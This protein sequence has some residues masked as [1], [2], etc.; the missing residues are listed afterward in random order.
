MRSLSQKTKNRG[1]YVITRIFGRYSFYR[2]NLLNRD[3]YLFSVKK[4][5]SHI[6]IFWISSS[7]CH[8]LHNNSWNIFIL[9]QSTSLLFLLL[10]DIWWFFIK[11]P[12]TLGL[13]FLWIYIYLFVTITILFW[14]HNELK[15]KV[16]EYKKR[17]PTFIIDIFW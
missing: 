15:V 6:W 4:M 16:E 2:K 11:T 9:L 8:I 13:N 17:R 14:I 12:S 10:H 1:N 7:N 5:P 3:V